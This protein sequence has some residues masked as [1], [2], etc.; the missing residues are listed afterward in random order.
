MRG[1]RDAGGVPL[2]WGVPGI[3]DGIAMH[4]S[5]RHSLPSRDHIA[6]NVELMVLSHSLDGW[7]GVTN[8]DKI[9]P[10][11]LLAAAR[12]DIPSIILTGG[13]MEAGGR[14]RDMDLISGFEAVGS[15]K[16]GR[17]TQEEALVL[18]R[19][20][21]PGPGS[22]AGLFT[23]NSMACMTEVLGMSLSGS[24]PTLAVSDRK[25]K[26]A[27]ETGVR[28][29][30]LVMDGLRP[31]SIM[32]ENAFHNA[33][34]VDMAIGGSTNTAL[35]L[36]AIARESGVDL[37]LDLFDETSRRIPN[38]CHISPSGRYHME[39]LGRAGGIPA[40]LRRL[41][42]HLKGSMTV[43]GSDIIDIAKGSEVLDGEV[44]RSLEDPFFSEGGIAILKGSLAA[45]SV[46]KQIAVDPRMM[47]HEGPAKV[48]HD[49][50]RV[51]S[52]IEN[53][54]IAEG[55]I[56]V[57]NFMGPAGAPGMP[58]MLSPTAAIMGAG[59]E[60]VALVT[61]GRFSGGTRGPCIGHVVPE[62][63]LGGPIGLVKDGDMISIDIPGRRIDLLVSEEELARRREGIKPPKRKLTPLLE[64]YRRS[65]IMTNFNVV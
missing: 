6:D 5:M 39:D 30:A 20:I 57:I 27:Y 26:E 35:H 56:V 62:A 25:R 13:P 52:A 48:F 29:V 37:P 36:P 63:Y 46:V 28:A 16:R 49:E 10:G 4:V 11:M 58:E 7:V 44:I 45:S 15:L 51:L 43:E 38:I 55:D 8:C 59:L 17:M 22:C 61:D 50:D 12:L 40:V 23:A 60:R 31:S 47:V 1:I 54:G 33:V 2:E 34:A 14:D 64:R 19:T 32:T 24:E 41:L 42:P 3:C 18:E 9:T 65:V 21:C 53:G